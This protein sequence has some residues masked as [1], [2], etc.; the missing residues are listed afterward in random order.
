MYNKLTDQEREV[1]ENK[2]TE[3]AFTGEY[4]NFYKPGTYIC[5]KCNQPLF[6][7]KTKFDAGC[8]WPAFDNHFSNSVNRTTDKDGYRT[9]ITCSNC[10][11]HLGHVFEGE[12]LTETNTRHCVNSLSIKFIP[13]SEE[14][15]KIIKL[16]VETAILAGGCFWCT[17]AI[18]KN[19]KGVIDVTPGYTGGTITNP[20]YEDVTSGNSGHAEAVKIDY[21][22]TTITFETILEIFFATHDPTTLNRQGND[23]GT[24]YRSEI[25]YTTE[26]QKEMAEKYIVEI[27]N[28]YANPIV[29]KISKSQEFYEAEEYHMEYYFKNR[30]N[31]YCMFVISPKLQ[32][33]LKEYSNI[34]N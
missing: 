29:T 19:L 21:D 17:E 1:I 26:S 16:E 10:N 33:V 3:P 12:Q 2:A 13:E 34:S 9:E 20:T 31:P 7:S 23:I 18:F 22:P 8:G 30:L 25:F 6:T 15:P 11:G 4:D 28:M 14:L 32:K 24:Q 5:R 27:S